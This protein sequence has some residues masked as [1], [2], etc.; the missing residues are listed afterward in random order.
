[1]KK[2]I[3]ILLCFLSVYCYSQVN[4]VV[5]D[6]SGRV[7]VFNNSIVVAPTVTFLPETD[8]LVS[9]FTIQPTQEV[10]QVYDT[11]I[12]MLMDSGGWNSL[13][14]M[15]LAATYDEQAALQN[16]IEN[17]H[18]IT[19]VRAVNW[20]IGIGFQGTPG[21]S[22]GYLNSNFNMSTDADSF[23]LNSNSYDVFVNQESTTNSL[24]WL[25]VS[26]ATS[27]IGVIDRI[28]PTTD[29]P[30]NNNFVSIPYDFGASDFLYTSER[31]SSSTVRLLKDGVF[32]IQSTSSTSVEVPPHTMYI[33]ARNNSDVSDTEGNTSIITSVMWGGSV[34]DD[35]H[36][37]R[38]NIIDYFTTRINQI[39]P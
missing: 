39:Y 3:T 27:L 14:W 33:F 21:A 24:Y 38:K 12:R 11:T 8:T 20:F 31:I 16:W 35:T 5:L 37:A 1:M 7:V 30:Y 25:G 17:D 13:D 19:Q 36:R 29:L 34:S 18:N 28:S 22:G 26:S 23:Q 4:G 32:V 10:K 9:R 2:L 15:M 6:G